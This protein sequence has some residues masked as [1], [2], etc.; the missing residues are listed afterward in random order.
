MFACTCRPSQGHQESVNIS[1]ELVKKST[2]KSFLPFLIGR[3]GRSA[4]NF[5]TNGVI[6]YMFA[7]TCRPSPGHQE[8]VNKSKELVKKSTKNSFLPF[9]FGRI[10]RN[11]CNFLTNDVIKY[12]FACTCRP[13][14]GH[15]E[16]V[17]KSKELV[18][19]STKNS[20]LP[21]LIGRSACNFL[22]IDVMKYMFACTCRPS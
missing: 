6:K 5:L 13:S 9:L 1:K 19:I 4:C 7:C 22:T 10:G 11:V 17:N 8:S 16:S 15:Q 21:F 18:K 12:M 14:P 3:I 20:F 2:K